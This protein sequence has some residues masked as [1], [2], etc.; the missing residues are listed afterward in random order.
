MLHGNYGLEP[1]GFS[2][3]PMM[4]LHIF[5]ILSIMQSCGP[6]ANAIGCPFCC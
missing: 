6:A 5:F 4:V 3:G 1:S 2:S